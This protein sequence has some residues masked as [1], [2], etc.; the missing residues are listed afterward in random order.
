M[1]CVRENSFN[2]KN[3]SCYKPY[4]WK[5]IQRVPSFLTK[6]RLFYDKTNAPGFKNASVINSKLF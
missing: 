6:S 3:N 1:N 5:I 4:L 2:T